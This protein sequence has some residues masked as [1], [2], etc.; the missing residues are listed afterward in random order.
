MLANV[1][2]CSRDCTQPELFQ[3][4]ENNIDSS[5]CFGAQGVLRNMLN[6]V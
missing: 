4:E 2:F 5:L 1:S 6:D 3:N